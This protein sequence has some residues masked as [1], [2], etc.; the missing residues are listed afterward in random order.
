MQRVRQVW[1]Q[2]SP[3]V[4]LCGAGSCLALAWAAQQSLDRHKLSAVW[5]LAAAG[6]LFALLMRQLRI[7]AA[8]GSAD[9]APRERVSLPI[10]AV[11]LG[12]SLT[13][14]LDFSG[15]RFRA[16]GLALWIGGLL[17]ALL[18]LW[19]ISP[20]EARGRR[21]GDWWRERIVSIPWHWLVLLL[22]LLWGAWLR[23][24]LLH[25][26]PAD[27]GW[28]LPYN[29]YDVVDILHGKHAIFFT[30]NMG[31]ESLFFYLLALCARLFGLSQWTLQFASALA[32]IGTIVAVYALGREAFNRQV[33]LLAALLLA[34]NRWHI[35]LSRAGYRV[36]LMPL[37]S[38]L[39]LYT[40]MK[41]LRK[42]R[43][44]DWYWA[45]VALGLGF[46]TYKSYLFVPV[47]V[48]AG[49]L[50]Y[51]GAR[52]WRE[53]RDLLPGL[54][55]FSAVT[56]VVFAPLGRY[57]LEKPGEYFAR[58]Q[59]Q[60]NVMGKQQKP[61]YLAY[62]W[63]SLQGYN[64]RGDGNAR[65]NVPYTRHMGFV[66]GVLMVL[67]L[68]YVLWRWREGYNALLLAA[69]FGLLLPT[70]AAMLP[71]EPAN[72]FRM[73]GVIG[74]ALVLAALPP[75]LVAERIRRA[76]ARDP[77]AAPEGRQLLLSVRAPGRQFNWRWRLSA[78]NVALVVVALAT[79][80]LLW[81]EN[82]ETNRFYFHDYVAV[83]P[84]HANFSMA[85]EVARAIEHYGDL[86]STYIKPWPYWYDGNALRASLRLEDRSRLPDLQ[87]FAPDQPPL[88]TLQGPA[89]FI[90]HPEDQTGLSTLRDLFPRGVLVPRRYPDGGIAFYAFYCER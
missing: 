5:G 59:L 11:T 86:Q 50:L 13:G 38:V 89:M 18:Y 51:F 23:L 30:A 19:L 48:A 62:Y 52:G 65:F 56:L 61:D 8:P 26:I 6:L 17:L 81:H 87:T 3:T 64:V 69:E 12:L 25:E 82:A 78:A 66:S 68:G 33:G 90:L 73:S 39:V 20:G 35:T 42:R 53:L 45:G 54:L 55:L 67:G 7:E 47:V 15:N 46:Y 9:A 27:M 31:R 43:F 80:W 22:I 34:V 37:F 63:S 24:H 85:R 10:L 16:L 41:A 84:D 28:D 71:G 83:L 75:F 60:F 74:P 77:T 49:L 76:A 70:A 2:P 58:E 57:I 79:A 21:L 14:V 1:S 40:L 29:Y 44:L 32:G 88:S 36:I 4:V 72:I